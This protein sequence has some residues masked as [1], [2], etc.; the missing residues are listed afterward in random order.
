MPTAVRYRVLCAALLLTSILA[1]AGCTTPAPAETTN[2]NISAQS[3]APSPSRSP[4]TLPHSDQP[5]QLYVPGA[6]VPAKVPQTPPVIPVKTRI[7]VLVSKLDDPAQLEIIKTELSAY[8]PIQ[9]REI[10]SGMEYQAVLEAYN[11][12]PDLLIIA[13]THLL[14]AVDI[15]SASYLDRPTLTLGGQIA[16][17]TKNVWTVIW[18]GADGRAAI[19]GEEL[20]FTNAKTWAHDAIAV[21]LTAYLNQSPSQVFRLS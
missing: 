11:S 13:G 21:G 2:A 5:L 19:Q 14:G 3:V 17:P 18:P 20:P 1:L 6:E 15:L 9:W 8:A 7:V 12:N 16:E 10:A 4:S